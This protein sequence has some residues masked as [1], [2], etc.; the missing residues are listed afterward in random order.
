ML[1]F[2]Q[3]YVV[4]SISFE[5]VPLLHKFQRGEGN[6][7]LTFPAPLLNSMERSARSGQGYLSGSLVLGDNV[8]FLVARKSGNIS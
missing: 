4:V 5:F 8:T 7:A 1:H 6:K 2:P 3:F